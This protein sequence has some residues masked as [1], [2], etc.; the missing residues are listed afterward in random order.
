[1]IVDADGIARLRK[2]AG[3]ATQD[4]WH[5]KSALE[6]AFYPQDASYIATFHPPK[7]LA[8]LDELE[9][10]RAESDARGTA[11]DACEDLAL[12]FRLERDRLAA[13]LRTSD[14]LFENTRDLLR[15]SIPDPNYR[16]SAMAQ[17]IDDLRARIE[18]F[19]GEKL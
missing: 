6:T 18:A 16:A 5:S 14:A 1:M 7:V 10:A 4:R 2:I 3:K 11:M 15:A 19:L 12:K 13:L 9:K 17:A 8:L